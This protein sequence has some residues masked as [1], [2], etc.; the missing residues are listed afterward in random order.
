MK[1]LKTVNFNN[2]GR[3]DNVGIPFK[4]IKEAKKQVK[5]EFLFALKMVDKVQE[6]REKEGKEKLSDTLLAPLVNNLISHFSFHIDDIIRINLAKSGSVDEINVFSSPERLENYLSK[7]EEMENAKEKEKPTVVE[8]PKKE[9]PK[10]KT[11]EEINNQEQ[12]WFK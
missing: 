3:W 9:V 5:D 12:G 2:N 4:I 8:P 10:E 1:N 7:L 6:L 11:I